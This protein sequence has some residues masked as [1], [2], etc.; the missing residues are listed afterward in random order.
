ML[1]SPPLAAGAAARMELL[2]PVAIAVYT[3]LLPFVITFEE[4]APGRKGLTF[5]T[6]SLIGVAVLPWPLFLVTGWR[7]APAPAFLLLAGSIL[8]GGRDAIESG[9]TALLVRSAVF[10]FPLLDA[11]WLAG[12]GKYEWSAGW[13]IGWVALRLLLARKRS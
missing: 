13:L 2:F 3:T 4:R 8:I 5:L 7:L 10:V 11:A 9:R 12:V 6:G 1:L